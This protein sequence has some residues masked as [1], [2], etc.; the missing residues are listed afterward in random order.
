M[1]TKT[2]KA[3]AQAL[4]DTAIKAMKPDTSGVAYRVPDMRAKGLE[5]DLV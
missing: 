3:Q 1:A 2:K 4:T 5:R